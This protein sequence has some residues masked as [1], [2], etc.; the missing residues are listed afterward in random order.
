MTGRG[1]D[2]RKARG[3]IDV[4]ALHLYVAERVRHQAAPAR[5]PEH[6]D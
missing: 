3:F 2:P 5:A 6:P 1:Y 4:Q